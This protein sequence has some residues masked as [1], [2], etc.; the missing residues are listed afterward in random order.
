MIG[1]NPIDDRQPEPVPGAA[2]RA[3]PDEAAPDLRQIVRP[4]SIGGTPANRMIHRESNQLF[5]GPYAI[6]TNGTVR[7]IPYDQMFGDANVKP[8]P[9]LGPIGAAPFYAV[10]INLG[11]LGTKG[12]LKCDAQARVLDGSDRPIPNLYAAG[13]NAGSPF[14]N[15]YPGAGGTIGPGMT[16][17]FVAANHI[18]AKAKAPAKTAAADRVPA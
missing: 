6:G 1:R 15:C 14:G 11:D 7:A 13:N 16:F 17:G 4:E 18:A 9:C 10:A 5:I 12:G 3:S 2:R 8:N